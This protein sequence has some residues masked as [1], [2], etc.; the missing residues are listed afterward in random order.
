MIVDHSTGHTKVRII[1]T[2]DQVRR[3]YSRILQQAG[4]QI[5]ILLWRHGLYVKIVKGLI[6][7]SDHSD[8][9]GFVHIDQTIDAGGCDSECVDQ[10]KGGRLIH[11]VETNIERGGSTVQRKGIKTDPTCDVTR[12]QQLQALW[13]TA[14]AARFQLILQ[15]QTGHILCCH[16]KR[17]GGTVVYGA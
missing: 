9:K 15:G 14:V 11:S 5:S 8:A 10:I 3:K 16:I 4:Q 12:W 2:I 6:I 1:G 13:Q 17:A 7:A